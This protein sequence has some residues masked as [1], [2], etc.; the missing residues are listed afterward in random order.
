MILPNPILAY[1]GPETLMPVVSV[2]AGAGGVFMWFSR[3]IFR[4]IGRFA[5]KVTRS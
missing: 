2:I 3:S 1:F 4:F 5:R